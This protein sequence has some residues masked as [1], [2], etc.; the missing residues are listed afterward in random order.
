MVPEFRCALIV[1]PLT[2][3]AVTNVSMTANHLGRMDNGLCVPA[4]RVA[5]G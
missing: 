1:L 2:E 3:Y 4:S 5:N